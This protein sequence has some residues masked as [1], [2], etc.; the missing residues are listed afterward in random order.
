MVTAF[1]WLSVHMDPCKE[2]NTIRKD[3]N[4]FS[5]VSDDSKLFQECKL[6]EV[7]LAELEMCSMVF[8][9][10]SAQLSSL[11]AQPQIVSLSKLRKGQYTLKSQD[12]RN[13]ADSII[14][15]INDLAHT[16][17]STTAGSNSNGPHCSDNEIKQS[18][19]NGVARLED[20]ELT[21]LAENIIDDV[22]NCFSNFIRGFVNLPSRPAMAGVLTISERATKRAVESSQ[23]NLRFR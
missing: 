4:N 19:I 6:I 18:T 16:N 14:T 20:M 3:R 8:D 13:E 23:G 15:S 1:K 7:I 9:E 17:C 5:S 22:A 10:L 11:C 21:L 2:E 12:R